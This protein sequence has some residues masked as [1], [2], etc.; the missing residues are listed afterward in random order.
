MPLRANKHKEVSDMVSD[1]NTMLK[2]EWFEDNDDDVV[3]IFAYSCALSGKEGRALFAKE[4]KA[5]GGTGITGLRKE[6]EKTKLD[7]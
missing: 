4:N 3:R 1:E 6:L 2:P 5:M 7:V